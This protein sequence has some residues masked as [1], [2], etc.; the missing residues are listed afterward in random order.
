VAAGPLGWQAL[1]RP[2]RLEASGGQAPQRRPGSVRAFSR[3]SGIRN[4]GSSASALRT[5]HNK[6][7]F[8]TVA[9]AP[10]GARYRWL[11]PEI[12]RSACRTA[13]IGVW[14]RTRVSLQLAEVPATSRAAGPGRW[15]WRAVPGQLSAVSVQ[16][17]ASTPPQ[18]AAVGGW[19]ACR[20]LRLR[21]AGRPSSGRVGLT[22]RPRLL[23]FVPRHTWQ[24]PHACATPCAVGGGARGASG[25]P[26]LPEPCR[27][28]G[29]DRR[30]AG[31]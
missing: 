17:E 19:A 11:P 30:R 28:H 2:A 29:R 24:L 7:R 12:R 20:Q 26:A 21:G 27:M 16:C 6:S 9:T 23:R 15:A 25:S 10:W 22:R 18:P 31:D 8:A 1:L 14:D 5:A 13:E 3:W 4:S